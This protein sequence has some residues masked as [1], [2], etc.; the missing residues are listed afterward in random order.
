MLRVSISAPGAV[1]PQLSA[2][3]SPNGRQV[4]FVATGAG[5]PMLWVRDL[6][7][8]EP[9]SIPG[10]EHAAHPFW[11]PNGQSI[12]FIADNQIK[13]VE[14]PNGPVQTLADSALRSGAAWGPD[15]TILFLRRSDQLVGVPAT[16]GAVR[17]VLT[18]T[19]DTA[20]RLSRMAWPR[21]LPDGRHFIYF[22]LSDRPELTGI[23]AGSL[24]S[25]QTKLLVRSDMRAWYAPPGYLVYPRD[26]ALVAHP[27]DPDRLE[28][29]G[30]ATVIAN[31]IWFARPAAQAS[32]SV[33][34]TGS[35]AYVNATLWDAELSW[36]DRRGRPFGSVG[37]PVR[38]EGLTPRLSPDGRQVAVAR[39]EYGKENVW[40]LGASDGSAKRLTFAPQEMDGALAWSADGHRVM[41]NAG[42][43]LFVKDVDRGTEQVVLDGAPGY[44][45]DWSK[46]GR[47]VVLQRVESRADLVAIRLDGDKTPFAVTKSP[48][49]ETQAQFS[50]DGKWIA[51]TSNETGRDEIYVQSFPVPSEKRQVSTDGGAMPRWRSDGKELFFVASNQFMTAVSVTNATSLTFGAP[52]RLFRTRLVVEGSESTGLATKYDVSPGGDRFVLRYPPE[53]PGPPIT[54][55]VNWQRA[56]NR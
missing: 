4:A 17:T 54:V 50:P 19:G 35:L 23:Y 52:V 42:G 18:L 27:F 2:A 24:G 20:S 30:E 36:F 5:G 3:I 21:F 56:L 53:D 1:T 29:H 37:Q 48:F 25:K 9:R 11:S 28:V 8:L 40:V 31:G 13:R 51:Y 39:G 7:Q 45:E 47:Y 14:L 46:D 33:S 22:G 41:Y 26:E 34:E 32:F 44:L 6:D 49:N 43:R 12:G 55:V 15:G 10:T 16:G 38:H